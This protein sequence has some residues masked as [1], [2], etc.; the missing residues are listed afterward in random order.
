[1][2]KLRVAGLVKEEFDDFIYM[3]DLA[4]WIFCGRMADLLNQNVKHWLPQVSGTLRKSMKARRKG[5]FDGAFRGRHWGRM[6]LAYGKVQNAYTGS[7]QRRGLY[8]LFYL[9]NA[10]R[11]LSDSIEAAYQQALARGQVQEQQDKH[12]HKAMNPLRRYRERIEQR[13]VGAY[14]DALRAQHSIR[15]RGYRYD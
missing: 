7:I 13:A 10:D 5:K 3:A 4:L 1:M 11:L 15:G 9:K 2:A 8:G 14:T 12:I 6:V